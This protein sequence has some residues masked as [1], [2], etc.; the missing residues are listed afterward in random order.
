MPPK[1]SYSGTN[2]ISN[3][4]CPENDPFRGQTE[5]LHFQ[6]ASEVGLDSE[7]ELVNE[8]FLECGYIVLLV[9]DEHGFFVIY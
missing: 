4:I 5:I 8:D 2:R 3:A 1:T 7:G 9:E 6:T